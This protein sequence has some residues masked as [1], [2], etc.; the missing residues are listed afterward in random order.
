MVHYKTKWLQCY[1]SFGGK[2]SDTL[3]SLRYATF[4]Q[5]ASACVVLEPGT[6]PPTERAMYFHSFRLH[7]QVC[8]WKYLNLHCLKLEEW[9]STFVDKVLK[10]FKTVMQPVP[11]LILKFVRC[12]C[13]STSKMYVVQIYFHLEKWFKMYGRVWQLQ[14]RIM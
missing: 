5:A 9:W 10:P 1:F 8:Q 6:L 3:A 13:K 12:K 2:N 11:E 7:L 14:R 4:T